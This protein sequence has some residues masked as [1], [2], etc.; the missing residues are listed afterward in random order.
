M[1]IT[2][3]YVEDENFYFVWKPAGIATSFGQ[4]HSFLDE[5]VA[6]KPQ[7]FLALQEQFGVDE[8]YWLLNRLDNDTAWFIYFA[9]DEIVKEH[10]EILQKKGVLL[11]QYV[12]DV[13]G[14]VDI[15]RTSQSISKVEKVW[16]DTSKA[17]FQELQK[18]PLQNL[19]QE[20]IK[21]YPDDSDDMF[22]GN[23]DIWDSLESFFSQ[24]VKEQK[25]FDV[26]NIKI[27]IMHSGSSSDRMVAI[28]TQQDKDHGRGKQQSA[29]SYLI[30]LVYNE[31]TN[32]TRCVVFIMQWV[33]HQ[34]RIHLSKIWYPIVEDSLYG[35]KQQK[36]VSRVVNRHKKPL[37]LWSV[38]FGYP[39]NEI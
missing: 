22:G 28:L 13:F 17:F 1:L 4:Q 3:R 16:N 31:K 37:H 5:I 29:Q 32:T 10:Y 35:G 9:K 21:K 19:F 23:M 25:K 24:I 26:G 30:P 20:L 14:K 27:P 33:R 2:I 6:Q 36:Q 39:L 38:W 11:K 8:E 12:C 34:I 18:L 7:F 15:E